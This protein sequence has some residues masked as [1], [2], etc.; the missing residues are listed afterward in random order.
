MD[1]RQRTLCEAVEIEGKR[2]ALIE[3]QHANAW[4]LGST[5]GKVYGT[6]DHDDIDSNGKLKRRL[7]GLDM[8]VAITPAEAI[9]RRGRVERYRKAMGQGV[10]A[11]AELIA[12]EYT[13]GVRDEQGN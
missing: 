10:E 12:K 6:I 3:L 2:Y 13:K 1:K 8:L 9:E 5:T 4:A 7:N 11:L